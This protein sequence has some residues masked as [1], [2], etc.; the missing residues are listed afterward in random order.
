MKK[1]A[2][3]ELDT[4]AE[5][6]R[7]MMEL[8][9]ES[10]QFGTTFFFSPKIAKQ[11]GRDTENVIVT[12]PENLLNQMKSSD[13]DLVIF[14][15]AHRYFH[16]VSEVSKRF[17]TAVI[18]HNLNFSRLTPAQLFRNVFKKETVFRMKL[19]LKESLL[20]SPKIYSESQLLV[21]DQTL[22]NEKFLYFPVLFTENFNEKLFGNVLKIAVPGAV[23]Q[24]RRDY[25]HILEKLKGYQGAEKIE[26]TF[27]GKASGKE[28]LW[29]ENFE[30]KRPENVTLKYFKER[31]SQEKFVDILSS[32]HILWCPV[33]RETEFFSNRETYGDTKMSGNIGDAIKFAKPAVFPASYKSEYSFVFPEE[34]DVFTQFF[35]LK[36]DVEFKFPND[37]SKEKV[38]EN[39]EKI[40]NDLL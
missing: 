10:S 5:I 40:L 3:I 24:K 6:A 31:I 27:A 28:V 22:A 14:G 38:R 33:Q 21:L 35:R 8:L 36:N 13:F 17:K 16:V 9:A 25:L 32:A 20:K 23:S 4:H 30:K 29:L 11:V 34:V 15:T 39:L 12:K 2:Y 26:I 19:L 37:F 18:T 1:I 7:N